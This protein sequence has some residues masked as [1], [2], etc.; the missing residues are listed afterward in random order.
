M[1]EMPRRDLALIDAFIA[2]AAEHLEGAD[3][4]V[5][6]VP[7][8]TAGLRRVLVA[9]LDHWRT[10]GQ[11]LRIRDQAMYVAGQQSRRYMRRTS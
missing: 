4:P 11:Q 9:E 5:W 3:M 6:F 7:Y 8:A 2:H 10:I 1:A